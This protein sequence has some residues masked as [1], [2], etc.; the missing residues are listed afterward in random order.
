MKKKNF[1]IIAHVDHRKSTLVDGLLKL[2]GT[3]KRGHVK[4]QYLDKL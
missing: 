3:I 2:M 1:A 4:L